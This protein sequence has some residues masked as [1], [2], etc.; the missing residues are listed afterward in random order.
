MLG[1]MWGRIEFQNNLIWRSR[2]VVR[3]VLYRSIRRRGGRGYPEPITERAMYTV[4]GVLRH[5]SVKVTEHCVYL[6]PENTRAALSLLDKSRN[7]YADGR[8][9][10]PKFG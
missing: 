9:R 6:R 8:E 5:S 10:P 3:S 7:S 4:R 1:L 2:R